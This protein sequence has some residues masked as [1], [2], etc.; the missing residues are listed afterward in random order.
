MN[1]ISR[2]ARVL[3]GTSMAL[4]LLVSACGSSDTTSDTDSPD[5]S[6]S[7]NASSQTDGSS[8]GTAADVEM[9][10]MKIGATAPSFTYGVP[11][12]MVAND[13]DAAHGLDIDYIPVG[14]SSTNVIA[15]VLSG[16]YNVGFQAASTA[17][18]AVN[19]GADLVIVAGGLA[20]ASVLVVSPD[21]IEAGGL[22][23]S[24]SDA[25]KIAALNGTTLASSPDGSGN[26]A[27]LRRI[28][29]DEGLD[30]DKDVTIVGL[31][32]PQAIVAGVR[33]GRFDGGYYGSGILE[34]N[35][36]DGTGAILL[37]SSELPLFKDYLGLSAVSTR[38]Y[39]D[40]HPDEI[41]AL[42]DALAETMTAIQEDPDS[43]VDDLQSEYF[44]QLDPEIFTISWENALSA[45]P[46][47]AAYPRVAWD[48][49]IVLQ[50]AA[51]GND[52]SGLDYENI[53][54]PQ[55]QQ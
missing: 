43:V 16:E 44:G 33:A 19:E 55:A 42:Y 15:G 37:R 21:V 29:K 7:A 50:N 4:A 11:L 12:A 26:N 13:I 10:K 36:V 24:S 51:T 47:D 27:A 22:D 2:P 32:D 40:A 38:K 45:Y 8:A 3:A 48:K 52:Y 5:A 23:E 18:D 34:A 1:R 6:S 39:Y 54:I 9:M 17:L 30:P 31:T 25:D 35:V 14:A 53:V 20:S 28:L 46:K 49:L 41:S